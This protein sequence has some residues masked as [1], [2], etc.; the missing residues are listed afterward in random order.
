[1][2]LTRPAAGGEFRW[3]NSFLVMSIKE[4]ELDILNNSFIQ[5][6]QEEAMKEFV[7][8]IKDELGI[9]A[10]PAGMLAKLAAGY[11]SRILICCNDR[12]VD[13][14]RIMGVMSLGVKQGQKIML[15][16]EGEDEEE[17]GEALRKFMDENL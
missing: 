3:R 8:T 10:R 15:K 11:K 2:P 6:G 17:A 9:H 4:K 12:E 13:V 5:S 7:Y 14:K 1:M 16:A